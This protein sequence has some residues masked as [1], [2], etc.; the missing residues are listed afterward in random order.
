MV[1]RKITDKALA[2][3]RRGEASQTDAGVSD[4]AGNFAAETGLVASLQTHGVHD[5]RLQKTGV[6]GGPHLLFAPQWS[7][8]YHAHSRGLGCPPRE[9]KIQIGSRLGQCSQLLRQSTRTIFDIGSPNRRARYLQ[10]HI[11]NC[12]QPPDF[13]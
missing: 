3:C 1:Q 10:F 13:F 8:E 5:L 4:G 6:G 2:D 7:D 12:T 9:N 11:L